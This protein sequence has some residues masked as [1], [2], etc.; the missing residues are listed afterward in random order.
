MGRDIESLFDRYRSKGDLKALTRV[1]DRTARDLLG[2][3][4]HLVRDPH[5]AEDLLQTT[6]V[7]AIDRADSWDRGRPLLPWLTGILAHQAANLTR[8]RRRHATEGLVEVEGAVEDPSLC[9]E[10]SEFQGEL[11]LALGRLGPRYR[12][13]LEPYLCQGE[14]PD[15]IALALG[16]APGTVRTQIYRGLTRLRRL[17]PAGVGAG[18]LLGTLRGIPAVRSVVLRHAATGAAPLAVATTTATT[19]TTGLVLGASLVSKKILVIAAGALVTSLGLWVGLND[20][21][22]AAFPPRTT[23]VEIPHRAPVLAGARPALVDAPTTAPGVDQAP[24]VSPARKA[25]RR[26]RAL[27]RGRLHGVREEHAQEVVFSVERTAQSPTIDV[28]SEREDSAYRHLRGQYAA[29]SFAEAAGGQSDAFELLRAGLAVQAAGEGFTLVTDAVKLDGVHRTAGGHFELDLTG[30]LTE[31][32]EYEQTAV[33][34]FTLSATHDVYFRGSG[35]FRFPPNAHERLA[36][37]EDVI[38]DLD[39]DLRPAAVLRGTV[40]RSAGGDT[41]ATGL[42]LYDEATGLDGA[43]EAFRVSRAITFLELQPTL[44]RYLRMDAGIGRE[45]WILSVGSF[46]F[47]SGIELALLRAE[48]ELPLDIA[49]ADLDGSFEFR[50]EQEGPFVIVA[51][52]GDRPPVSRT[53]DLHLAEIVELEEGPRLEGLVE[54]FGA[55]PDGGIALEV[56]RLGFAGD[57]PIEWAQQHLGWSRGA[58]VRTGAGV[59]TEADGVFSVSGL[60]PG[61]HRLRLADTGVATLF[62]SEERAESAVEVAVPATDVQLVVPLSVLEVRAQWPASSAQGLALSEQGESL[63]LIVEDPE[64]GAVLARATLD[65]EGYGEVVARPGQLLRLRIEH[66]GL[67]FPPWEG[68]S[69]AAG[70]RLSVPLTGTPASAEEGED[71]DQ[72]P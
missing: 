4:Q 24:E 36:A 55:F 11:T 12:E 35:E 44:D 21:L 50:V 43:A 37:G 68:V 58:V 9:A 19:A 1:F 62:T 34:Y 2:L 18:L 33:E 63:R 64:T 29:I 61:M 72:R 17:L 49:R 60:T 56:E 10:T 42:V 22:D 69:P 51:V 27:V 16:R 14:K 31:Q 40:Q 32:G 20:P 57:R 65:G 6:F 15:A 25:L 48:G 54:D 8:A 7:T 38:V 45:T 53:V 59:R 23:A 26:G 46:A 47:V 67:V 66:Q 71:A 52:E 3:A 13:V 30:A 70:K 41:P 5:D 39:V 28:F